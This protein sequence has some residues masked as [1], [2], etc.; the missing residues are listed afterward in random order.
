MIAREEHVAVSTFVIATYSAI[1]II[2]RRAFA[3]ILNELEDHLE[4]SKVLDARLT[5]HLPVN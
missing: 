1:P 3:E 2:C 5:A 4:A